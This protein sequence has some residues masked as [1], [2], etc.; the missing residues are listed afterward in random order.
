MLRMHEFTWFA[1]WLAHS[2]AMSD[3]ELSSRGLVRGKFVCKCPYCSAYRR[4][5]PNEWQLRKMADL[6]KTAPTVT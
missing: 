4:G 6:G 2:L 3:E 5:L 1:G